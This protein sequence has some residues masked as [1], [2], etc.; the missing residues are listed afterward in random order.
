VKNKEE[1]VLP[2]W[3]T[4]LETNCFIR[5]L[6]FNTTYSNKKWRGL[7]DCLLVHTFISTTQRNTI[8]TLL[9][10]SKNVHKK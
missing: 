7:I 5:L 8:H 4:S 1:W 6:F 3:P 10:Y 9:F 2:N